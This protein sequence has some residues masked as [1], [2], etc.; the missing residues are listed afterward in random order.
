MRTTTDSLVPVSDLLDALAQVGLHVAVDARVALDRPLDGRER[1][2]VVGLR[3]DA[4]PV[5][6]EVD[7][8]DL[9]GEQRLA[10]VRAAV[11]HAGDLAQ[12]LAGRDRDLVSSV[13]DVPGL[14]SQCIRKSRS[15]KLGSSDEPSVGET[16][17]AGE[18]QRRAVTIA[19]RGL[20]MTRASSAP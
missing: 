10:D 8:V 7:A 20:R 16:S 13:A 3:A 19:G 17:S 14:V 12:V 4:D 1:L 18:Q 15:L 2:V 6:A 11:A 9:V 5:L